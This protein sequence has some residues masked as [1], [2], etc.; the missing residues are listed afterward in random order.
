MAIIKLRK[1]ESEMKTKYIRDFRHNYLV[2]EKEDPGQ[3]G[4][5]IKMITENTIDGL[6]PCQERMINGESLLYYDITSRQSIQSILEAQPLQMR[7]LQKLFSGLRTI[8]EVMEKY[9]LSPEDL[10]LLPEFVYMDMATGEYSFIYYPERMG[11]E[12]TSLRDLN[13]FFMQHMDSENILLVEAVYQMTDLLNRQQF[14]LDELI[15]WFQENY[16]EE[17]TRYL[18][19]LIALALKNK[20]VKSVINN[21]N[22]LVRSVTKLA[23]TRY[24]INMIETNH[25]EELNNLLN[26]NNLT[27]KYQTLKKEIFNHNAITKDI[28]YFKEM[29]K[30]FLTSVN[31]DFDHTKLLDAF[32]SALIFILQTAFSPTVSI[33]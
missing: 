27:D 17:Q 13:E 16:D 23:F 11:E 7:H 5:L 21:D 14:V 33:I 31:I 12:N 1:G 28:D 8:S 2:I 29:A 25:K 15:T 4:Y 22:Y 26:Y 30:L 3:N 19:L 9:L 18:N 10:L 32:P 20:S 6:I 24:I